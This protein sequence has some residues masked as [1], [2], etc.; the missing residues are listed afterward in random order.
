MRLF[1]LKMLKKLVFWVDK[2][3]KVTPLLPYS[4]T[5]PLP[6]SLI[7]KVT[8]VQLFFLI[9]YSLTPPLPYSPTPLLRYP[10]I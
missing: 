9:F 5:P 8:E 2:G 6:Y 10:N 4:P 1:Q 7:I 3:K